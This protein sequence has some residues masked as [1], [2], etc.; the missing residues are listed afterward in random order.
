MGSGA[1]RLIFAPVAVAIGGHES[2]SFSGGRF[3]VYNYTF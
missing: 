1:S 3:T 2:V